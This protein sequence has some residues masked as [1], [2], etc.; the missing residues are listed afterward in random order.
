MRSGTRIRV[1]N[2]PDDLLQRHALRHALN[3]VQ[4]VRFT[5]PALDHPH[6]VGPQIG[7]PARHQHGVSCHARD[8]DRALTHGGG[9]DMESGL[10]HR[11]LDAPCSVPHKWGACDPLRGGVPDYARVETR[12]DTGGEVLIR[13]GVALD[14]GVEARTQ[15]AVGRADVESRDAS[16]IQ[17]RVWKG[18]TPRQHARRG[19][20]RGCR[21]RRGGA[22]ELPSSRFTHTYRHNRFAP[23]RYLTPA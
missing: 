3:R 1:P 7:R 13:P 15:P 18:R 16:R 9:V 8:N 2:M 20:H 23:A 5:R 22:T 14:G 12:Q 19:E 6:T 11:G 4:Q 21:R 10:R 17:P